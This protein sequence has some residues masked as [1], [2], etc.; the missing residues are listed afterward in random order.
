MKIIRFLLGLIG[1]K[2]KKCCYNCKWRQREVRLKCRIIC[3]RN[4]QDVDRDD[5]CDNWI[6]R[7]ENEDQ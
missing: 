3:V 5:C 2:N 6:V 4:G 7:W 1:R